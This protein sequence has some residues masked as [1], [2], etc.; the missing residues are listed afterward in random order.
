MTFG[1]EHITCHYLWD[2]LKAADGDETS[3]IALLTLQAFAADFIVV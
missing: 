2:K 3:V 1:C